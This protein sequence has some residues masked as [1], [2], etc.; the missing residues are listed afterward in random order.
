MDL[1]NTVTV[2]HTVQTF[3]VVIR[4]MGSVHPDTIKDFLQRRYEV[5]ECKETDATTYVS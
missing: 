5:V 1:D 2:D 4:S 3:T